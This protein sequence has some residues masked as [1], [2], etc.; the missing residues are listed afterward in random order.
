M[1][2]TDCISAEGLNLSPSSVQE[3]ILN[4]LMVRLQQ[5]WSFGECRVHLH[6]HS[7]QVHSGSSNA[8]A[9]GNAEYFLNAIAP[10][11]T[12]ASMVAPKSVLSTAQ[13]ELF[14]I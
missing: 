11:F 14:D 9:L 10:S 6:C 2:Y 4:S 8:D 1:E 12:L 13:I 3:M 7:S 5:C